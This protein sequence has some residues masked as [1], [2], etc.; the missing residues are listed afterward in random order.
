MSNWLGQLKTGDELVLGT[1]SQPARSLHKIKVTRA[2]VKSFW[3][4]PWGKELRVVRASG[5]VM[6][7]P[8]WEILELT[9]EM[10]DKIEKLD[11]IEALEKEIPE[12]PHAV[13]LEDLRKI[14]AY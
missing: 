3:I 12:G 6:G 14:N 7:N 8:R 10:A 9:P 5:R 11:L 2:T 13:S 4:N 1:R